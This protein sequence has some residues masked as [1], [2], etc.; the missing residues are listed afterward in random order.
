MLWS[1]AVTKG[2]ACPLWLTFKQAIELGGHGPQGRG[3][4]ACGLCQPHHPHRETDADGEVSEREIPFLL[5]YRKS[6]QVSVAI[7]EAPSPGRRQP[8]RGRDLV[9]V[10]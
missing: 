2:Y 1:A 4:R 3:R 8:V 6:G 10:P 7:I 9:A 5:C